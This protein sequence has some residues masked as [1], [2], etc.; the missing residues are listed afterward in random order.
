VKRKL[1][2]LG[3]VVALLAMF[4]SRIPSAFA[5]DPFSDTFVVTYTACTGATGGCNNNGTVDSGEPVTTNIHTSLDANDGSFYDSVQTVFSGVTGTGTIPAGTQVG[6]GSFFIH[7]NTGAP[8]DSIT[9]PPIN[10]SYAIYATQDAN[11]L[12]TYPSQGYAKGL[13]VSESWATFSAAGWVQDFDDDNNNNRPDN[14]ETPV[15]AGDGL[16]QTVQDLNPVNGIPDGADKEPLY[17]NPLDVLIGATHTIRYFGDAVVA[18]GIVEVPVDFISYANLPSP[19]QT[20]QLAV[21]SEGAGVGLLPPS[22]S[23][24]STTTCVPFTSDILINGVAGGNVVQTASGA[25]DWTFQLS[26]GSDYDNDG[27]AQYRDNCDSVSNPTQTD[28]DLDGIGDACDPAPATPAAADADSDGFAN[29][30]DSC[31]TTK[32]IVDTDSDGVSNECDPA[33]AVASN[34]QGYASGFSDHDAIQHA[35]GT[36]PLASGNL[37]NSPEVLFVDSND[38]HIADSA[39]NATTNLGTGVKKGDSD[40]DG[41]LDDTDADALNPNTNGARGTKC[42]GDCSQSGVSTLPTANNILGDGCNDAD[43]ATLSGFGAGPFDQW[44]FY[45]VPVPA[46]IAST[47]PTTVFRTPGTLSAGMAQAIFGYF[48]KSAKFGSLE[49]DQDLNRNNVMDGLEYDRSPSATTFAAPPDGT[50]AANDA[51]KAFAQFKAGLKCNSG[52]YR[53]NDSTIP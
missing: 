15:P 39:E 30:V 44:M 23:G 27:F 10:P 31:P 46:L 52:G 9:S 38:N 28:T 26:V 13:L 14:L 12:G 18:A 43:E 32:S 37:T 20:L 29:F 4:G 11:A 8:C 22:P 51:Q 34:G 40:G 21:I 49:Y 16:A 7:T 3:A 2:V 35:S 42:G 24:S 1:A 47:N 6:T 45:D 53:L 5:T 48:K 41:T 50:I 33:P 19:G 17:L 25:Q 36:L